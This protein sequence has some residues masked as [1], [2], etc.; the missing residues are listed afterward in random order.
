MKR[1]LLIILCALFLV[2]A[3]IPGFAEGPAGGSS[4]EVIREH[5][6]IR[7]YQ[8]E[9]ETRSSTRTAS[10]ERRYSSEG[11]LIAEIAITGTFHYGGN[12]VSV[13]SKSISKCVTY[14]GWTFNR[15]SFIST[16]GSIVLTGTL[17]KSGTTVNVSFSLSCD[18]E[19]NIY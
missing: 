11:S 17:T 2:S 10:K 15:S 12:S 4:K 14:D 7:I 18:P 6:S 19:G 5:D 13:V 16:G 9:G 3:A 8:L 1:T